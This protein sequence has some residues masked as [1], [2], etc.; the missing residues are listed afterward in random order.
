M[1]VSQ[2][3]LGARPAAAAHGVV[4]VRGKKR[5]FEDVAIKKVAQEIVIDSDFLRECE[6]EY[7]NNPVN[8]TL[9]NVVAL[10]GSSLPSTSDA[11]ARLIT[12]EFVD[13]YRTPEYKTMNQANSGRC[14]MY[15]GMNI[16]RPYI[17][18]MAKSKA[19]IKFSGTYLF[20]YDKLERARTFLLQILDTIDLDDEDR[21]IDM[22]MRTLDSDGGY[23]D[24][25]VNLVTKYGLVP[26]TAMPE[27]ALSGYSSEMNAQLVERL[28]A[29]AFK[30]R[31]GGLNPEERTELIESTLKSIYNDLAKCLGVPPKKFDWVV[32]CEEG[33]KKR[34]RDLTPQAFLRLCSPQELE[35]KG[36][37]FNFDFA[38]LVTLAHVPYLTYNKLYELKDT[39][40]VYGAKNFQFLNVN[41]REFEFYM[42]E[43]LKVS[44]VGM[45][46]HI[47]R[48]FSD[49]HAAIDPDLVDNTRIFDAH[50]VLSKGERI[51][52][53]LQETNH[54]MTFIGIQ[55]DPETGEMTH[56]EIEN[57][58][59]YYD[60]EVPTM[61]G[62]ISMTRK[63]F[64]ESC[65]QIA[66]LTDL[67][68]ERMIRILKSAPEMLEPWS[69]MQK[70]MCIPGTV[71][72]AMVASARLTSMIRKARS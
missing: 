17:M 25:F 18:A 19:N 6:A 31:H 53:T 22:F 10:F 69:P 64:E 52:A 40:N 24:F 56:L 66:V 30:L 54:A 34:Y 5:G 32:T 60:E 63:A 4:A 61:D 3:S 2:A 13:T 37:T 62:F 71:P 48:D 59:G 21:N 65:T 7:R 38:N 16:V 51:R 47:G 11:K 23:F 15:A 67:L 43:Q 14:W 50:P 29:T 55:H 42:E 72:E 1:S 35:Y 9:R 27:T 36:K 39:T 68:P 44:P 12:H 46:C 20:F 57:S 58:W 45:A 70:A 41:P 8:E 26:D 49:L 28:K 33:Q